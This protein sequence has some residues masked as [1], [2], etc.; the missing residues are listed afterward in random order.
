MSQMNVTVA[1]VWNEAIDIVGLELASA[2][3]SP[4]PPFSAGSHIDV[5]IAPGITRQYS[6]CNDHSESHR[7]RLGCCLTR[8]RAAV[9]PECT[10]SRSAIR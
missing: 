8:T 6:L 10:V 1:A 5:M 7:Y 9:R 2:D 3:G 4:L